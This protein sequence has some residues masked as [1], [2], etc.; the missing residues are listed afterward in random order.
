MPVARAAMLQWGIPAFIAIQHV[1]PFALVPVASPA[2]VF[3]ATHGT[4][5]AS[6]AVLMMMSWRESW[7][8]FQGLE[9]HA[10]RCRRFSHGMWQWLRWYMA[11]FYI[12]LAMSVAEVGQ[13]LVAVWAC[14]LVCLVHR[15]LYKHLDRL[16]WL[17]AF[18]AQADRD[19][20]QLQRDIARDISYMDV[21]NPVCRAGYSVVHFR[22]HDC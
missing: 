19:D 5:M 4:I 17:C 2:C 20:I 7:C 14:V 16:M 6:V 21:R 3:L 1:L 12:A 18:L 15:W 9:P 8:Y 10:Q 13:H 22:I 11:A